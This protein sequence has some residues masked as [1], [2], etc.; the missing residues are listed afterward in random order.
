MLRS[1]CGKG[2]R[3]PFDHMLMFN[4]LVLQSMY[5]LSDG[6]GSSRACPTRVGV[7]A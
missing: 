7:R 2:G 3:P 1:D 6:T 5:S 4:V